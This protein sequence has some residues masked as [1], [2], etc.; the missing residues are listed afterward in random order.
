M[1]NDIQD[2]KSLPPCVIHIRKLF[3]R[4]TFPS[5]TVCFHLE[6]SKRYKSLKVSETTNCQKINI[7]LIADAH[8]ASAACRTLL[9]SSF[10]VQHSTR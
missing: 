6:P 8:E 3:T 7:G 1:Q 2:T 4:A 5:V 9:E 10:H